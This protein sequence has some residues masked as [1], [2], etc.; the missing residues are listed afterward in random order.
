LLEFFSDSGSAC[1][2]IFPQ[3]DELRSGCHLPSLLLQ[4]YASNSAFDFVF[5]AV[6][7]F[8]TVAFFAELD[9]EGELHRFCG[10]MDGLNSPFNHT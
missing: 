6:L 3:L 4:I 1:F 2:G 8:R 9:G 5:I 10:A 7:F